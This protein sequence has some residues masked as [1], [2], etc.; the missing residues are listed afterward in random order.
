[1]R[2][3]RSGRLVLGVYDGGHIRAKFFSLQNNCGFMTN[4]VSPGRQSFYFYSLADFVEMWEPP[5]NQQPEHC[6]RIKDAGIYRN[7]GRANFSSID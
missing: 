2:G 7:H 4:M 5:D 3:E 1:M 6:C